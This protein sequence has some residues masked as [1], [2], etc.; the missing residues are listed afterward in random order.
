MRNSYLESYYNIL[1][2]IQQDRL[3]EILKKQ[4]DE[5]GETPDD[6]VLKIGG[7]GQPPWRGAQGH[8]PGDLLIKVIEKPHDFFERQESDLFCKIPIS[9]TKLVFG[10]SIK[11]PTLEEEVDLKIPKLTG[12]GVQFELEG[13]G[14]PE[15]Y[16]RHV[17][18]IVVEVELKM[19]KRLSKKH[20][21]VLKQ[22]EKVE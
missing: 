22:L 20:R 1:S 17:G 7:E 12:S 16:G 9:Y 15:I 14:L 11:V 2:K 10:T 6:A 4:Y 19:P 5:A 18:D 8:P 21:S 3:L 13:R